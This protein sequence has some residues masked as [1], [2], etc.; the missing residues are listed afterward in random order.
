MIYKNIFIA[1]IISLI[2]NTNINRFWLYNNYFLWI[3]NAVNVTKVIINF[4]KVNKFV[5]FIKECVLNVGNAATTNTWIGYSQFTVKFVNVFVAIMIFTMTTDAG[6]IFVRD[7]LNILHF[8]VNNT[9]YY[10]AVVKK[11]NSILYNF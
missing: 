7:N 10:L 9:I 8:L 3:T 2:Q 1:F 4:A 6:H 11:N 5:V